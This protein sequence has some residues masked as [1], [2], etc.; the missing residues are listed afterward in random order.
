MTTH[1]SLPNHAIHAPI[2][3][4]SSNVN[5]GF[6][7]WGNGGC[8]TTD[9]ASRNLLVSK[10]VVMNNITS[11]GHSCGGPEA[12]NVAYFDERVKRIMLFNI[13]IFQD[14]RRYLLQEIKAEKKYRLLNIALLASNTNLD[15]GH[16]GTYPA[17]NEGKLGKAAM[18]YLE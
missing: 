17:T 8:S 6:I 5:L 12:V 7:L 10:A 9:S 4:P 14:K 18:A 1:S 3:S 11:A 15:T 13:A 16:R 2:R